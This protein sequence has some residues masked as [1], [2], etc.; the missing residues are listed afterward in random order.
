MN[1]DD[2]LDVKD[3]DPRQPG[4]EE[5]IWPMAGSTEERLQR[6]EFLE[7]LAD[8]MKLEMNGIPWREAYVKLIA[9]IDR[10][11]EAHLR[12]EFVDF[13]RG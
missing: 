3:D 8:G 1:S 12:V 13:L 4:V 5:V 11:S 6:L 9:I 7:M 2:M 10:K